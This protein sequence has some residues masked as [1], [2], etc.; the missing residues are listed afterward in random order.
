M[1]NC[2]RYLEVFVWPL[3]VP[4][5]IGIGSSTLVVTKL[6]ER[7]A[8]VERNITRHEEEL[9]AMRKR[10]DAQETRITRTESVLDGMQRDTTEIKGDV[11][12][13]L[14]AGGRP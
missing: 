14:R 3:V 6:E 13:L 11:K 7:M 2:Q 12:T 9:L 10:D 4:I 8:N 5:L 1:N